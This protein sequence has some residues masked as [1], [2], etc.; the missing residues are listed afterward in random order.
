MLTGLLGILVIVVVMSV[1]VPVIWPLIAGSTGN[2][3]AMTDT[4]AGT[5]IIKAFWPIAIILVGIGVGT[6]LI[7]FAVKKMGL[8]SKA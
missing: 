8:G 4:S 5:D 1:A 3:T 7:M 2:I 6:G